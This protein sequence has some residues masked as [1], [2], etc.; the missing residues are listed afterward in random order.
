MYMNGSNFCTTRYF[1]LYNTT[2]ITLQALESTISRDYTRPHYKYHDDPYLTPLSKLQNRSFA[3]AKESGRK[4][5]MWICEEHR[6]LFQHKVAEP[7]IK[8]TDWKQF[9]SLLWYIYVCFCLYNL[10]IPQL[11]RITCIQA[12]MPPP[13]YTEKS[14]VTEETLLSEISNGHVTN[15]IAIYDLLD[16]EVSVPAKQ[17]FLEL[18][19]FYNNSEPIDDELLEGRWFERSQKHHR[20]NRWMW[21]HGIMDKIHITSFLFRYNELLFNLLAM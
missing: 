10:S 7:E 1:V 21:V 6:D 17:A 19:C 2:C 16:G 4:A 13:I 5:A 9:K 12:F 8:V 11:Y 18:L 15:S 14:K 3:L 20:N